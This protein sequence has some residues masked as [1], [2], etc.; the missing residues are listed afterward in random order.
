MTT[1][2]IQP[3]IAEVLG[4]LRNGGAYYAPASEK[5]KMSDVVEML[6]RQE[7]RLAAQILAYQ[8][9]IDELA[10]ELTVKNFNQN[11]DGSI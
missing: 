2:K 10:N 11:Q 9:K 6:A 1:I 7:A 5:V 8:Q 3:E 4:I